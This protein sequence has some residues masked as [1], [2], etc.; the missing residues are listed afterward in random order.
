[1]IR[2]ILLEGGQILQDIDPAQ[3]KAAAEKPGNLLW[4]DVEA[5]KRKALRYLKEA[6]AF[7]DISLADTET[8]S[9][10]PKLDIFKDYAFLVIHALSYDEASSRIV[11][12]EFDL[13]LGKGFLVTLHLDNMPAVDKVFKEA[14]KSD[15]VLSR[16][17]DVLAH[18]L[19]DRLIDLAYE[20]VEVFDDD[21]EQ[22]ESRIEAGQFE[23]IVAWQVKLRRALLTMRK[24]I[25]P[26]RDV[27]NLLARRESPFISPDASVY[28][29]SDYDRLSRVFDMVDTNR[30]LVAN[31]AEAY[32]SMVSL[33]IS[34]VSMR[35]NAVVEWLSIV[36]TIFMPLTFIVGIYGMNFDYMPEL[37]VPA[38]YP[39]LLFSMALLA[40]AMW[41]YF[42]AKGWIRQ[43]RELEQAQFIPDGSG[44]DTHGHEGQG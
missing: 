8:L 21:I 2:S 7:D 13:F 19:L 1:M 31:A 17:A 9:K 12:R 4:I 18:I 26:Q 40:V 11:A 28:F 3:W 33:K 20:M 15:A 36:A 6:F 24:S 29:R 37:H 39:L 34:E 41:W 30:E 25:G 14:Q 43:V 42:G 22:I 38:A 5:P 35:T 32:R 27:L 44:P 10:L 23:G 16:G